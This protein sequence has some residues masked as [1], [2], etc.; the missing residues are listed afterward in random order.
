M[1]TFR[2][3]ILILLTSLQAVVAQEFIIKPLPTQPLLPSAS[4]RC[5]Y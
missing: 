4:T 2:M 3:V 5:L 1:K